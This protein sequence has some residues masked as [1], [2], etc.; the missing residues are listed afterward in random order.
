VTVSFRVK[1]LATH[2]VIALVVGAVTL[3]VVER[4]VTLRMEQ[5]LDQRLEAQAR[6]VA[7]WLERAGHLQQLARRLAGVVDARVTILD[8]SGTARGESTAP[9]SMR[10]GPDPEGITREIVDAREGKVGR[11]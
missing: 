3:L 9:S 11:A 8:K 4:L 7:Q 1:L 5:Q 6:A 10:P 2:A